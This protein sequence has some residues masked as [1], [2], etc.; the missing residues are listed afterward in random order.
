MYH[1]SLIRP[2]FT[3]D[4]STFSSCTQLKRDSIESPVTWIVGAPG[5]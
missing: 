1:Q 2:D 3:G 4:L 5:G